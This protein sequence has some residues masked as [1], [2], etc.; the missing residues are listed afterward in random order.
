MPYVNKNSNSLWS[1]YFVI[2]LHSLI[3]LVNNRDISSLNNFGSYPSRVYRNVLFSFHYLSD[4]SP[5]TSEVSWLN[6]S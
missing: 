2:E 3:D 4:E 6:F 5:G 1:F